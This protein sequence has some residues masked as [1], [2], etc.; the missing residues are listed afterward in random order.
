MKHLW[1]SVGV[2]LVVFAL[3]GC[4]NDQPTNDPGEGDSQVPSMDQGMMTNDMAQTPNRDAAVA[5]AD[6]ASG[7]NQSSTTATLRR[8]QS[9]SALHDV[10]KMRPGSSAGGSPPLHDVRGAHVFAA[11]AGQS[12]H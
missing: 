12:F 7:G 3:N 5:A 6:A 11:A 8:P 2:A 1:D 10:R 9:A 4:V